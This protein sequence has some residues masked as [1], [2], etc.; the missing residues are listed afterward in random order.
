M[1]GLPI[2]GPVAAAGPSGVLYVFGD[3]DSDQG[4]LAR[5]RGE[6]AADR[7]GY[8]CP[9]DLCRDSNGPVWAERLGRPVAP[10]L[11]AGPAVPGRGINFAVSGAHMTARGE[12]DVLPSGVTVQIDQFAALVAGGRIRPAADD[13]FVIQAGTNDLLRLAEGDAPEAIGGDIVSAASG[14]VRRLA[15][16]GAR[17]LAVAEV[18]PVQYL[19]MVAG[20]ELA[21]LRAA[22]TGIVGGVNDALAMTLADMRGDLPAGTN[23]VL[24]RQQAFFDWLAANHGALG[25]APLDRACIDADGRLCAPDTA[26][27]DRFVWFDSNHLSGSGHALY[28]RWVQATLDGAS[29]A[30]AAQT[31]QLP[32][33]AIAQAARLRALSDAA[34]APG[35]SGADRGVRLFAAPLIERGRFAGPAGGESSRIRAQGGLIGLDARLGRGNAGLSVGWTQGRTMFADGGLAR[36]RGFA[37]SG[38]AG[39]ALPVGAIEASISYARPELTDIRRETGLPG[40]VARGRTRGRHLAATL[41]YASGIAAG[42]L[43]AAVRSR[44]VYEQVRLGGF[45]ETAADG[46]ALAYARQRLARWG[47]E[48]RMEAS[49]R[50]TAAGDALTIAPFAELDSRINLAGGG[51]VLTSALAGN[52]ALPATTASR[53]SARDTIDAGGGIRLETRTGLSL[54]ARYVR[55]VA[56]P[57]KGGGLWSLQVAMRF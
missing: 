12:P 56:G 43:T 19:P 39:W 11:A 29:G 33:L 20:A 9:D 24:I 7:P 44:I 49:W 37:V 46:L 32:D 54:S 8:F 22:L 21:P 40:L 50:I 35:L 55:A 28:A 30:A 57:A 2:A 41:G 1:L 23:I 6:R 53:Q 18:A 47:I 3:S 15:G 16:L 26:A 25:L 4:N 42:P 36:S 51:H 17:T 14:H 31:A 45:E 13:L 38:F 10:L 27:Q 5:L 34:R 52:I 48:S